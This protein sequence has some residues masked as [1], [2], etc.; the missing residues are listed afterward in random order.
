MIEC[1]SRIVGT[2]VTATYGAVADRALERPHAARADDTRALTGWTAATPLQE[3]LI[4][5]VEWYR[6]QLTSSVV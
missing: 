5:T 6:T 4:R 3:G 1:V 2:K